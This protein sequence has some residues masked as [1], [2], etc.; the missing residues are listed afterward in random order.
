M[1]RRRRAGFSTTATAEAVSSKGGKNKG[2]KAALAMVAGAGASAGVYYYFLVEWEQEANAAIET[3]DAVEPPPDAFVHPYTEKPWYWRALFTLKRILYIS[4]VFAPVTAI[5]LVSTYLYPN[6][7]EWRKRMLDSLLHAMERAGCCFMKLGQ[8]ISM[9]PDMFP[10]DVVE[11][12]SRLRDGVPPH[13][14][15]DTLKAVRQGLGKEWAEIFET[16]ETKPVA[17]GTVAQVHR[18]LLKEEYAINGTIRDV[19]VKVRHPNILDE[20]FVDLD[21]IF[22]FVDTF[23]PARF[24]MPCSQVTNPDPF[25]FPHQIFTDWQSLNDFCSRS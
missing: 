18:G 9:R 6:S 14:W 22:G 19:A 20:T 21:I 5:S 13:S 10:R 16:L 17:S 23:L 3:S 24:S 25:D 4:Y 12:M 11:T 1:L 2:L 15:A 7:E 8:W